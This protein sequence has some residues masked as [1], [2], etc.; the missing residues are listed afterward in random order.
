MVYSIFLICF[1]SIQNDNKL[2]HWYV[3]LST[4]I[5]LLDIFEVEPAASD[6]YFTFVYSAVW[7]DW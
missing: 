5:P 3:V 7:E 1:L 6:H 4:P 2:S